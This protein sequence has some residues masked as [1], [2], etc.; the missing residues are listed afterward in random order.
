VFE[1]SLQQVAGSHHNH[2]PRL[3]IGA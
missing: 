3:S 1:I 2:P